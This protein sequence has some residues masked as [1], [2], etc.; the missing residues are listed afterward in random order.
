[1]SP[2]GADWRLVHGSAVLIGNR[3]ILIR[4]PSGAGKTTL[5]LTL[6]SRAD[7]RGG[8][9]RL[10][11]D[12]QI[13]VTA[14]NGA[15][16]GRTP[17]TIRGLAELRGRGLIRLAAEPLVRI[18]LVIDLVVPD[19]VARLPEAAAFST[20]ICGIVLPRQPVPAHDGAAALRVEATYIAMQK[21][22]DL[23]IE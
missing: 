18:G 19:T 3:A 2:A 8:L 11:A 6:I 15:L 5:A 23:P 1:M 10:V 22:N 4:G 16:I 7:M 20:E 9:A 14:A 13:E 21:S 12:D 17:A